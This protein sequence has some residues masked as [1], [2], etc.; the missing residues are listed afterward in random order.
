MTLVTEVP[1][2]HQKPL[3]FPESGASEKRLPT[4]RQSQCLPQVGR[5]INLRRIFRQEQFRLRSEHR[6]NERRKL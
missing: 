3:A 6:T 5:K 4:D 1:Q 2:I